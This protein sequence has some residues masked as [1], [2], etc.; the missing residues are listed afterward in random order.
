M[1]T[2]GPARRALSSATF[3]LIP[4]L[5]LAWVTRGRRRPIRFGLGALA[6]YLAVLAAAAVIYGRFR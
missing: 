5:L 3:W 4:A 1:T 6:M 2:P